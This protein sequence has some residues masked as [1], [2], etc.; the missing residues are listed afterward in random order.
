MGVAAGSG[1]GAGVAVGR[2]VEAVR[3]VGAGEP[4]AE[5]AVSDAAVGSGGCGVD[6]AVGWLEPA[7]PTIRVRTRNR[8]TTNC[9][10]NKIKHPLRWSRLR[11][12]K[13]ETSLRT[14]KARIL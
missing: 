13:G 4:V 7:Q 11:P 8:T 10:E 9:L 14:G 5:T 3:S 12:P 2:A 6:E 1:V